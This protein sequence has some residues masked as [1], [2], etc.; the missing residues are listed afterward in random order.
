[1]PCGPAGSTAVTRV[2]LAAGVLAGPLFVVVTAVQ[3]VRRE[4]FDLGRH[5]ISLLSLGD[6][7]WVQVANFVL[8]GVLS[9]AFAVGMHRAL[10]SG[11]GAVAAP[12]L[13]AGYGLGLV[14]TGLFLVDPGVGFPPGT[15][16]GVP[17]QRS[18]HG[19]VH[20]VAPPVAFLFLVGVCVV[21]ALRFAR[22]NRRGWASYSALTGLSAICLIF[23]PGG[24]GS[25]RS[26]IAVVLTSFWVSAIA[27][28]LLVELVSRSPSGN[29][30]GDPG[31]GSPSQRAP[32]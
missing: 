8:A 16:D 22:L 29:S 3:V 15:A 25:V 11:F 21:L 6:G 5:G 27:I 24:A 32:R 23:W 13:T 14:V 28:E 2:L 18:W 12:V 1:M 26:A 19:A 30:D 17:A 9:I 20:A 7:G 4:G 10:R 31:L